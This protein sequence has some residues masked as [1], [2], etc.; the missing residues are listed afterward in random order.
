MKI[1]KYNI[2]GLLLLLIF[3]VL[4][5]EAKNQSVHK[6]KYDLIENTSWALDQKQKQEFENLV[7]G[8]N[9]QA[10]LGSFLNGYRLQ[11]EQLKN[12]S[13]VESTKISWNLSEPIRIKAIV[14][15]VK[16]MMLK[17]GKWYLLNAKGE[18]LK[19]VEKNQTLDLPII[20][21]ERVISDA[22]LKQKTFKVFE[23]LQNS[24]SQISI[25][26]VSEVAV[27]KRGLFF[28]FSP[29]YKVY[30]SD[31]NFS[32][33]SKRLDEVLNY[34]ET[35]KIAVEFI[36]TQFKNKILVRPKAVAKEKR[37]HAL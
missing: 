25:K 16:A 2:L 24:D 6:P 4:F 7:S 32:K 5:I 21:S 1:L 23:M 13:F 9:H 18:V 35:K 31:K 20:S 33:Q 11:L 29:G 17:N 19:Q 36:D 14:S 27:D 3:A 22:K 30:L 8:L 34:V 12:L 28:I 37:S 10:G 15:E 26:Q